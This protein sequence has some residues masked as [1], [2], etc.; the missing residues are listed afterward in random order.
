MITPAPMINEVADA[1]V[2]ATTEEEKNVLTKGE[3]LLSDLLRNILPDLDINPFYK[4][5]TISLLVW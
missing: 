2:L 1:S 3:Y 4:I 5:I